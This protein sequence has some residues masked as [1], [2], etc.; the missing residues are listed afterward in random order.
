[1]THWPKLPPN[2]RNYNEVNWPEIKGLVPE[3]PQ[4]TSQAEW[5][6]E[7]YMCKFDLQEQPND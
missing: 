7:M 5:F 3:I 1:M 2:S 6:K 4:G